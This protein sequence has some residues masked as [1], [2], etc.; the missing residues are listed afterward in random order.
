MSVESYYTLV[1]PPNVMRAYIYKFS[2]ANNIIVS[3]V[4][5]QL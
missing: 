5:N 1:Q 3:Q 2:T 4:S